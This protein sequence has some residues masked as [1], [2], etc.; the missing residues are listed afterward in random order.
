VDPP[1][2]RPATRSAAWSAAAADRGPRGGARGPG[3]AFP[4]A[5][6][7]G[8][9]VGAGRR[10]AMA[11]SASRPTLREHRL[12][13]AAGDSWHPRNR[14]LRRPSIRQR[15]PRPPECSWRSIGSLTLARRRG[16]FPRSADRR[17]GA[18]AVAQSRP[19]AVSAG[20]RRAGSTCGVRWKVT[21][22]ATTARCARR[23]A[24]GFARASPV[25][26]S[27]RR[28]DRHLLFFAWNPPRACLDG[29]PVAA[30]PRGD[31]P[32]R[33]SRPPARTS[34]RRD[35]RANRSAR[36]LGLG[37][38]A[39]RLNRRV[40]SSR[41]RHATLPAGCPGRG[42]HGARS[43]ARAR[44]PGNRRRRARAAFREQLDGLLEAA[45]TAH[46]RDFHDL[47]QLLLAIGEVGPPP[48]CRSSPR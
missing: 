23:S 17:A 39:A 37:N 26:P 47:D 42:V 33:V 5:R 32:P 25:G 16:R 20:H 9:G 41:A 2:R 10:R 34:W 3:R 15:P 6:R 8:R 46:P 38:L 21:R 40:P 18:P 43:V 19:G 28:R 13:R 45:W 22:T 1:G 11:R 12:P 44:R 24:T 27:S 48:A 29:W 14:G 31:D 4:A 35:V 36:R 30:G 7:G